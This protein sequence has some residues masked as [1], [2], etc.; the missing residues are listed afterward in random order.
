MSLRRKI[1]LVLIALLL[2]VPTGFMYFVA[3]TESGLQFLARRVTG[4]VGPVTI[5]M[6]GVRGTLV[7]GFSVATLHV[8]HRRSDVQI[9]GAEG[10][11]ELMPLLLQQRVHLR[12]AHA[13]TVIVTVLR[14]DEQKRNW[15]PHFLPATLRIDVD[16]ASADLVRIIT[17]NGRVLN[18]TGGHAV[19]TIFPK[20]IR[21]RTGEV[22]LEA[23][24][25]TGSG[26]VLAARPFGLRGEALLNYRPEGLPAWRIQTRLDGDLDRLPVQSQI[27]APFHA[28][29]NGVFQT[30]T[31][32]WRY[33]GRANVRDFD[34]V[35]FGGGSALGILSGQLDVT[36]N[37]SGYTA[38]GDVTAPGLKAGA[39]AVTFDGA[40]ADKHLLIRQATAA[41]AASGARASVHGDV[42]IVA[43]GP[44]LALSGEWTRFRW[45]LAANAPAFTSA[46]GNFKLAGQKPWQVEGDGLVS[47]MTWQDLPGKLRGT[48]AGD[49]LQIDAAR[50]DILGGAAEFSGDARWQPGESWH[51]AGRA[52]DIDP[53]QLRT[54]LPGQ[55]SFDFDARGAP[56][57]AG[58]ALDFDVKGLSG[59]LRGQNASGGGHFALAAGSEDWQFRNVDVRL[60]R[61]HLALNGSLGARRDLQFT[62]DAEDLSLLDQDA[63]G[64]I[65]ARGRIAGT[66]AAPVLQFNG[67]GSN[68]EWRDQKL[69]TLNADVNVDL[70]AARRTTGQVELKGLTI[71]NRTAQQ[72]TLQLQGTM[73]AQRIEASMEASPLRSTLVAEG[74]IAEGQWRGNI[75]SL[76]VDDA[77]KLQL[78]LEEP[79]ALQFTARPFRIDGLCLM[80]EGERV[81]AAGD[82]DAAGA[83]R[84][85]LAATSLPLLALTAGLTQNID[86]DGTINVSAEAAGARGVPITGNL[87]AQLRDAL[88][89]HQLS[90]GR[91]E[92]MSLGSG[93]VNGRAS[94]EAFE[95]QVGLDAGDAGRITGQI[96][97]QR[98]G[99]DWR[100]Y[101]IKG[102]LAATTTGL[103]VLDIY[104]GGIDKAS[105]RLTTDVSIAGTLGQPQIEGTLQLRDAQID[106]YQVNLSLRGLSMDARFDASALDLSGKTQIGNGSA[107][108]N[109]R[110]AWKDREPYGN[111]HIEGEN[112]RVVDVPE[113]RIDASPK[114]DFKLAGRRIDASGEVKLPQARI[115]P[116]D[117]T[118]AVLASGDEVLVGEPQV[119]P[120]QRW[121][122]VSDIRLTLGDDVNIN[123]QGLTAKLG[124]SIVL[125]TDES[126]SSRG[127]G[128][129]NV[130]SGKYR[131]LGRLL[132]IQRGRL[133]FNNGPLGDPGIDLRAQKVF[134][135]VTAGVNVRGTLRAPRMTFFSEPAIPQSQIASLILSGGSLASVTDNTTRPGAARNDLLMQ[136]GAILAQQI[137]GRVGIQDV[138]VESTYDADSAKVSNDTSLVL[139]RYLSPRFYVSYG[140]SLAEAINTLKLRY[141]IGD[142]WTL[143]TEAGKE[144]SADIVFTVRNPK[145]GK[146]KPKVTAPQATAPATVP[147]PSPAAAPA[148]APPAP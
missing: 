108:F 71:G 74:V 113:A 18:F 21:I 115:E 35:P 99:G 119:D 1:I 122:V 72:V 100:G 53:A 114:L 91:E 136:G 148:P 138:S 22:D 139:G 20:Q 47:A 60:G 135:G 144:R 14:D 142:H 40:Y 130:T 52:I 56:F 46:S 132:D 121:T 80:G 83:W 102:S 25:I 96:N 98:N 95:L 112:L 65:N 44:R 133:L 116:A 13:G 58:A 84:A 147:P 64:R 128:E 57:G 131:A 43:G 41:H 94:P 37:S 141:T 11:V 50:L 19:A 87:R 7:R 76:S 89:R 26:R 123:A 90:N 34:L 23:T 5:H 39:M 10:H 125:R 69:A 36:A 137:G 86:Y 59:R 126:G 75:T 15:E 73:D 6:E 88:L 104:V 42:D 93:G 30:L 124:G 107:A 28:Q 117:L 61:T 134:P 127:Q 4:K 68:F 103:G 82:R 97:G 51:L 9:A 45:P 24:H 54:D 105:G 12:D 140:I 55:L 85:Q 106:V 77:R 109:G 79:A 110:M 67:T 145:L 3:T 146:K 120:S 129:L 49:A 48:L 33:T 38:R 17:T 62:L 32:A 8:Q 118:N 16:R 27:Q 31:S 70:A 63:K 101:P 92:R 81:C 78:K 66:D 111:L 29:V 2:V 143:K